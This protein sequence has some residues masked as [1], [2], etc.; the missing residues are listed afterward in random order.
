MQ[1]Y[2]KNI[3]RK[4]SFVTICTKGKISQET[5][6]LETYEPNQSVS[7]GCVESMWEI[8]PLNVF[9]AEINVSI[10]TSQ[11]KIKETYFK[12]YLIIP[13]ANHHRHQCSAQF[14][15]SYILNGVSHHSP[16][17]HMII[18]NIKIPPITDQI[19]EEALKV[20]K[21]VWDKE[22]DPQKY[23]IMSKKDISNQTKTKPKYPT[24]QKTILDL[25]M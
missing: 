10:N 3:I 2:P 1:T 24:H 21:D 12:Y 18:C 22:V 5:F 19:F 13:K 20:G 17:H 11:L 9:Y 23:T 25:C 16:E 14:N 4:I 15:N 8:I 6:V 7:I